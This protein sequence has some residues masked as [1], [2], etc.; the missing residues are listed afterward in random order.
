MSPEQPR[1]D[2]SELDRIASEEFPDNPRAADLV[3]SFLRHRRA[4]RREFVEALITL[5]ISPTGGETTT[6]P[7]RAWETRRLA[8]LILQQ[9]FLRLP[10][11]ET[12]ESLSF[13]RLLGLLGPGQ[14][15]RR[16][17]QDLLK[18]GYTTTEPAAFLREFRR[19]LSRLGRVLAPAETRR[20]LPCALRDFIAA[21]RQECRLSLARYL[22]RPDEVAERVLAQVRRSAGEPAAFTFP[23]T[24]DEARRKIALL[25]GFEAGLLLALSGRNETLWVGYETSSQLNALVEQPVNTVVL[26]VKPP[27][28][29]L[30][31]EIKRAGRRA[32]RPLSIVH[33][34]NGKMVPPPHRLDGGSSADM[35]Q[36]EAG[37]A[38]RLARI[39]RLVHRS[40]PPVSIVTAITYPDSLPIGNGHYAHL[41]DYFS[42]PAVFRDDFPSLSQACSQATASFARERGQGLTG[43]Q[44]QWSKTLEFLQYAV[45]AQSILVGSTSFRLDLLCRYLSADGPGHHFGDGW[46]GRVPPSEVRRFAD[47]LLDETLGVYRPPTTPY[48]SHASYLDAA[49][50]RADNRARADRVHASLSRQLGTFWATVLAIRAYSFGESFV[51]RNVGLRAIW[52]RGRWTIRIIFM[53]HDNLHI[54]VG[55]DEFFQPANILPGMIADESHVMGHLPKLQPLSG[56]VEYL[57]CIYRIDGATAGR[58]L[59]LLRESM[60]R[61][62][63]K[64]GRALM[65]NP[66]LKRIFPARYVASS[67]A[68]DRVVAA[69]LR[70]RGTGS[71]SDWSDKADDILKAQ[72]LPA[73]LRD[74][75]IGAIEKFSP[76][77]ER[78]AFLYE[79][80]T[81]TRRAVRSPRA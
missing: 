4:Y 26:T 7:H 39:Y 10:A 34:R 12:R 44:G 79:D 62:Y 48:E 2:R 70:S 78:N 65:T 8:A 76:F 19:H 1:Q 35:L 31:F 18:E 13:L 6:L 3:D 15:S 43:L 30:E 54:P 61:A 52:V 38:A 11:G 25:P 21:S 74:R 64:T 66:V 20:V 81:C 49:F 32:E 55:G 51:A 72:G 56:A 24:D 67:Q 58:H 53:D 14:R 40:E 80:A 68:W 46:R 59:A 17:K 77:F 47:T 16:I 36:W 9:Q 60:V 45:P 37:H 23:D 63:R 69:Y 71:G 22:F 42:D 41:I 27:G 57:R 29:S 75:Y 73:G 50:G 33:D 5:A 28:S